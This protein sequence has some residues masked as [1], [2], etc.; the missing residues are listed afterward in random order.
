LSG[1]EQVVEGALAA[2]TV[3]V[4]QV[5]QTDVTVDVTYS[6]VSAATN[7]IVTT[8]TQ[9]TI[10]TGQ[11]SAQFGVEALDDELVE[12]TEI[13]GVSISNPQGGN[14]ERLVVGNE[15]VETTI[16]DNDEEP[17]PVI[18]NVNAYSDVNDN[19]SFDESDDTPQTYVWSSKEI[20]N[21]ADASTWRGTA[22]VEGKPLPNP[23]LNVAKD[24]A[25][26][27]DADVTFTKL[28]GVAGHDSAVGYY[29]LSDQ[30]KGFILWDNVKT[31]PI[32]IDVSLQAGDQIGYFMIPDAATPVDGGKN[33]PSAGSLVYFDNGRAY[34][35]ANHQTPINAT[36]TSDPVWFSNSPNSD[37]TQHVFTGLA[38]GITNVLYVGFEDWSGGGDKDYNDFVFKVDLGKGNELTSQPV[39]FNLGVDIETNQLIESA[40]IDFVL[41]EGDVL[42]WDTSLAIANNIEIV[43]SGNTFEFY[44]ASTDTDGKM[45]AVQLEDVLDSFSLQIANTDG[46]NPISVDYN[47]RVADVQLVDILGNSVVDQVVFELTKN[48]VSPS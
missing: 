28:S 2:Y 34:L 37:N 13:F 16:I 36:P 8:T 30:S 40:T 1:A 18:L 11:T 27:F 24:F 10:P 46:G 29:Y 39:I 14:F 25:L 20:F 38:D 43:R 26:K 45:D 3:S 44:A 31:G 5:P 23:E 19:E 6:Y 12:D 48:G 22:L 42:N 15:S 17:I 35:D 7:D 4:D 33:V 47:P 41:K 9:I 32:S 21:A